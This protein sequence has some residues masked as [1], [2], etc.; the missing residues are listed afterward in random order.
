MWPP[1]TTIN[2]IEHSIEYS[3][4]IQSL[5][6]VATKGVNLAAL[7]HVTATPS[8]VHPASNN[9]TSSTSTSLTEEEM[10]TTKPESDHQSTTIASLSPSSPSSSSSD[11]NENE[12]VPTSTITST[13]STTTTTTTTF[14]LPRHIAFICDGNSRWSRSQQSSLPEF[15]GHVAGAD[16][17][18][19]LIEALQKLKST[20]PS[21]IQSQQNQIT[22]QQNQQPDEITTQKNN[23]NDRYQRVEY[24][25]L[26]AFSTENWSRPPSEIS[27]LFQ[28]IQR[29]ATRYRNHDAVKNGKI[30]IQVLGDL[31]DDRI[32]EGTRRELRRLESESEENCR[33]RTIMEKEENGD[34]DGDDG[35]HHHRALTI[36][37]AIN[38]GGRADILRA[39]KNLAISVAKGELPI[40]ALDDEAELSRRMR[41]SKMPDPDL[42]VRTGGERRLSN[43]LLWDAAYAELYFSDVLWP[44]FDEGELEEALVWYGK[45]KRRF[46]GR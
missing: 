42:I 40:E 44:D 28:I 19:N 2:V 37:L 12:N 3:M 10:E 13:T 27:T 8:M 16:R 39:A 35:H 45:R 31:D 1:S 41:T 26:F 20:K 29:M 11:V 36:C 38:Y 7:A 17:V 24:C 9:H 4:S 32:P 18:V 43:F 6:P 23:N 25:T 5:F 21:K 14:D 46:G 34:G 33:R 30:R 15:M 22:N